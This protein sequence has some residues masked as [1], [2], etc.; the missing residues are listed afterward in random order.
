[1]RHVPEA[2][3][4]ELKRKKTPQNSSL[5]PSSEHPHA[6]ATLET[7][8][9]RRRDDDGGAV[10]CIGRPFRLEGPD[11]HCDLE[12]HQRGGDLTLFAEVGV[13]GDQ[14]RSGR[15]LAQNWESAAQA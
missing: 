4:A 6:K 14:Q 11:L 13:D 2:E 1:M 8:R 3:V 12:A 9:T 15:E 5:P 10:C 7:R